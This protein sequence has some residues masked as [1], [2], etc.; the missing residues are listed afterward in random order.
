MIKMKQ[1]ILFTIFLQSFFMV[2]AQDELDTLFHAL[3]PVPQ[4]SATHG[5]QTIEAFEAKC[6]GVLDRLDAVLARIQTQHEEDFKPIMDRQKKQAEIV[7]KMTE[8]ADKGELTDQKAREF[9]RQME[10]YEEPERAQ[11][12]TADIAAEKA[13]NEVRKRV[14]QIEEERLGIMYN[15]PPVCQEIDKLEEQYRQTKYNGG[16]LTRARANLARAWK[17]RRR[18]FSAYNAEYLQKMHTMIREN[19]SVLK[20][21]QEQAAGILRHYLVDM[22]AFYSFHKITMWERYLDEYGLKDE[23]I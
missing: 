19:W 15:P 6:Q 11:P 20:K 22:K 10:E 8:L 9:A 18:I 17:E 1:L 12:S 21:D 14:G 7:A 13:I 4:H 16:D 2:A 3:P 5:P 23:A